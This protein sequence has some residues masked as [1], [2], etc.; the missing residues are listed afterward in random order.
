MQT[1]TLAACLIAALLFSCLSC[2]T[3]KDESSL[4]PTQTD[5]S[6]GS[7]FL[8]PDGSNEDLSSEPPEIS[9]PEPEPEPEP[10]PP[11]SK[12]AEY[13]RCRGENVRLRTGAGTQYAV[14]GIAEKDTVYALTGK[15]G[16]W[17]QVLYR[18]KTA[19]LYADYGTPFS[20][21]LSKDERAE[22]VI[23]EGERQIGTPYVYG[24]I[25]LHD[26]K[27][28]RL[29]GFTSSAF[30]CSS[31]VQYIFYRGANV[32]LQVTTRTQVVQGAFV[33]RSS[34][35]RGD[36][37]Y[38]TNAERANRTGIERIGHVALYLGEGYILHTA[39]DY[40][41]I[42]KLSEKRLSYY[43]EARRFL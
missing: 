42:E 3:P 19:Y 16:N 34:L 28:N 15:I 13:L 33:P 25:R 38:F 36:C 30:D 9:V 4:P 18:G 14:L 17:Y 31:L 21:S 37:I 41:R 11:Q 2:A 39:S 32:L 10:E 20:L 12:T 40:A 1:K 43:V 29:S 5:E 23:R 27:G 24:A 8:P 22:A 35:R 7:E 6:V 26:G